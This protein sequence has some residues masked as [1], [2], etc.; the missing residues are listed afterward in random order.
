MRRASNDGARNN[1]GE[2]LTNRMT[3]K[4]IACEVIAWGEVAHTLRPRFTA[5]ELNSSSDTC[6]SRRLANE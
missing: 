1:Y 5:V 2:K 6:I 4:S 3:C